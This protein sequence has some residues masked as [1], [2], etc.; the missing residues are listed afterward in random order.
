MKI[1]F[2]KQFTF[3]ELLK[4]RECLCKYVPTHNEVL[5]AY[6]TVNRDSTTAHTRTDRCVTFI[7]IIIV[8][9]ALTGELVPKIEDPRIGQLAHLSDEQMLKLYF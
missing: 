2:F 1:Q 6:I 8:S 5:D 3:A 9:M 4:I 7:D